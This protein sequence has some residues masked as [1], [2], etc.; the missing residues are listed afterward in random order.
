MKRGQSKSQAI[1][2]AM[3][4]LHGGADAGMD[5][6]TRQRR[7]LA[8]LCRLI[9]T[10]LDG[11]EG[12]LPVTVSASFPAPSQPTLKS[13]DDDLSPRMRETLNCLLTGDSE[14]QA[15]AKLGVSQHTV[16][17]Y[18][19][20]LYRKFDVNSRGELLAKWVKRS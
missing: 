16:H 13:Q 8:D 19:K 2:K 12:K 1:L 6:T 14:K 10:H 17:V 7:L 15:A 5:S 18:V 9:G 20:Q 4:P 3:T 11:A